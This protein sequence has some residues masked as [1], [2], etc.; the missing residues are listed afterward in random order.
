MTTEDR[1]YA[2]VVVVGG[3]SC[4]SVLAARLSEDPSCSVVLLEVGPGYRSAAEI[5]TALLDA[6]ALPVGPRSPWIDGY[7]AELTPDTAVDVAR[8]RVLGGSGAVNGAYFV[9]ARPGDFDSWP[10]SWSFDDVLPYFRALENDL[11]FGG[12]AHGSA[13]PMPVSRVAASVRSPI[14]DTFF[15]A[16]LAAGYRFDAD[17]NDPFSTGGVGPVPRNVLGA[18]RVNAA[19]A[20][21]LPA[22]T[23]ANLTVHDRTT[24]L[25]VTFG[26]ARASGVT[27]ERGGVVSHLRADRIVLCAGSVRTPQLLMLSGIGPADPLTELGVP[28]VMDHPRVGRGFTDHPELLVPWQLSNIGRRSSPLEAVL[29]VDDLEIRPYSASFDSFIAGIPAGRPMIGIGLM[30]PESRGDITLVSRDPADAPRVRHR[31]LASP[32]DRRAMSDG[33][34]LVLDLIGRAG[35]AQEPAAPGRV[36]DGQALLGTSL[37]LS[38][39]CAMGDGD[40]V[41]DEFCRVRGI[42]GLFVVDTSAFPVV[43][44]RGPHATAIMFAERA[45]DLLRGRVA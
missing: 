28:V 33:H 12:D 26:G 23:R 1:G 39:S 42:E 36:G 17:K 44:S 29:H 32:A 8:G 14:T 45:S 6:C 20:Y 15:G 2:D 25:G 22:M 37:H 10:A 5:P 30:R 4:G 34:A 24:V 35:T 3:G 38:G 40:S 21:L 11:D 7:R 9:R 41:V 31:Y 16:A 27:V 13:G 19:S 43:P 18:R